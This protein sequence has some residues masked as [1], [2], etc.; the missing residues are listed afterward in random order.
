VSAKDLRGQIAA[1]ILAGFAANPAIFAANDRCGWSLVN[2]TDADIAGY[3]V[4]LA[5]H[6]FHANELIPFGCSV[7][8]TAVQATKLTPCW[9][10]YCGEPHS[11]DVHEESR[12][13]RTTSKIKGNDHG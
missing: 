12:A 2:A 3:A 13:T 1:R 8:E 7:P 10:P 5:D 11:P 4:R 6:L 9:C